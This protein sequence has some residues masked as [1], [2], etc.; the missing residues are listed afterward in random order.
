MCVC[1]QWGLALESHLFWQQAITLIDPTDSLTH[2]SIIA[3]P[4]HSYTARPYRLSPYRHYRQI[5]TCSCLVCRINNPATSRALMNAKRT[6]NSYLFGGLIPLCREH[7]HRKLAFCGLCLRESQVFEFA[8]NPALYATGGGALVNEVG[9]LE[10]EDDET[11]PGVE[12]T[13]RSCRHEWLWKKAAASP[14]DQA[15]LGGPELCSDDWETRQSVDGFIE[16]AEGTVVDVINLAREKYWLRRETRL[17]DMMQQA[18]AAAKFNSSSNTTTSLRSSTTLRAAYGT[19]QQWPGD[20]EVAEEELLEEE[21]ESSG[22]EDTELM[23]LEEGGVKDLALGDWARTRILDGYWI[24]PADLWYRHHVPGKPLDVPAVHPCPWTLDSSRSSPVIATTTTID[25]E[26]DPAEEQQHPSPSTTKA[27][28]P[29]SFNLCEQAFIAHGQQLRLILLPAMKNIVRRIAIECALD[30]LELS[31]GSG[32]V[33][34]PTLRASRMSLEE[35]MRLLREEE[36]VWYEGYDWVERRRSDIER[37]QSEHQ[38]RRS[39]V[40]EEH[41]DAEGCSPQSTTGGRERGDSSSSSVGSTTTSPVLSTTTLQTTPSPPPLST[42]DESDNNNNAKTKDCLPPSPLAVAMV[43]P[44]AEE[45]IQNKVLIPVEQ[46]LNPPKVLRSIP[47]VPVTV[48]H[49]PQ[50]SLDAF[51]NIWREA[52]SP[53]YHCRCRICERAVAAA[54]TAANTSPTTHHRQVPPPPPPSS[55]PRQTGSPIVLQ[56]PYRTQSKRAQSPVQIQL[57]EVSVFEYEFAGA[58]ENY[59]GVREAIDDFDEVEEE[60]GVEYD[61]EDLESVSSSAWS[62][63][64][65]GRGGAAERLREEEEEE[66]EAGEGGGRGVT[67]RIPPVVTVSGRTRK[68]SSDELDD[69]DDHHE[70]RKEDRHSGGRVGS[71]TKRQRKNAPL[72]TSATLHADR[73]E[74]VQRKRSSEELDDGSEEDDDSDQRERVSTRRSVKQK[75]RPRI[76][77]LSVE[78]EAE[79]EGEREGRSRSSTTTSNDHDGGG[80]RSPGSVTASE[81]GD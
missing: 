75:K 5:I 58:E 21:E 31:P 9:I 68:R 14:L 1:P 65:G 66:E 28:I 27:P 72:N 11:F 8:N 74:R 77:D 36:G 19:T 54:N 20:D 29:P 25:T 69:N 44:T 56:Q 63:S 17:G 71:P 10:N 70:D 2:L 13:C 51:K 48:A 35:V 39:G 80:S 16:L 57:R 46:V 45:V 22:E 6:I 37:E 26:H 53:L 23:Q 15:A 81:E 4:Q 76:G 78:G 12:A 50:F 3:P 59:D 55:P 38:R 32:M 43:L 47:H 62:L 42:T 7:E 24:S 79:V 18:L 64:R 52:C 60:E 34:D 33:T 41:E 30:N 49:L 40:V 61:S 73:V 67:L